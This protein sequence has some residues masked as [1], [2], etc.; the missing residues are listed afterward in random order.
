MNAPTPGWHPDPTGRHE[1]R[2]WDGT[3][4]TDD[5]SDN[6]VTSVDPVDGGATDATAPLDPT[7]QYGTPSGGY[8]AQPGYGQ[9]PTSGP[10][11][12]GQ[13]VRS[14]PSTGLIVGLAAVAVLL[15]AGIVFLVTRDGDDGDDTA[16]DDSTTTT[17]EDTSTSLDTSDSDALVDL[18]AQGII[19]GSGGQVTQEQAECA[20]QAMLDELGLG[21]LVE[22]GESGE[23]PFTSGALTDEQTTAII[24][25]MVECIPLDVLMDMGAEGVG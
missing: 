24:N 9:P 7:Q 1:Y 22:I 2:Y 8:G 3:R 20:A 15:I 10:H 17:E 5:V 11:P 23:D 16:T 12:P 13:P 25:A 21:T 14:G 19:E 6:G 4:W 18:M